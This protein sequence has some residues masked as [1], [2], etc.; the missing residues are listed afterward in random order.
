MQYTAI[1]RAQLERHYALALKNWRLNEAH[2]LLW[3]IPW[4]QPKPTSPPVERGATC[5]YCR[6]EIIPVLDLRRKAIIRLLGATKRYQRYVAE[7]LKQH[8]NG[9]CWG[10]AHR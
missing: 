1:N 2:C 9:D 4:D 3:N 8:Q 6:L 10:M 5:E 7:A